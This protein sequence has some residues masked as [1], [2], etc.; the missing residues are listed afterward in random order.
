LE[1]LESADAYIVVLNAEQAL[2]SSET[3]SLRLQGLQKSRLVVFVNRID[4]L[5]NPALDG[6]AVVADIRDRL[7]AKFPG[8]AIPVIAGSTKR[9]SG[10]DDLKTILSR[11]VLQGPAMLRLQRRQRALYDMVLNLDNAARGE[12]RSLEQRI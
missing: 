1:A 8:V 11:L 4:L 3:S 7:A 10:I 6:E 2:S 12:V 5:A 9:L